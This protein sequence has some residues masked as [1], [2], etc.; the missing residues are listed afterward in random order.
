[1]TPRS[2]VHAG[3]DAWMARDT[4]VTPLQ[5]DTVRIFQPKRTLRG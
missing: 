1:M 3:A 2:E 5:L 4:L